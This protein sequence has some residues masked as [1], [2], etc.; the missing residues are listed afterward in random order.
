MDGLVDIM[1]IL[2]GGIIEFLASPDDIYERGKFT[3]PERYH[4]AG[5]YYYPE[6]CEETILLIRSTALSFFS[7]RRQTDFTV[8]YGDI[9]SRIASFVYTPL[10]NFKFNHAANANA[11]ENEQFR[12]M[13]LMLLQEVF[14]AV[15]E[16]NMRKLD[17]KGE[18]ILRADGK[19]LKPD[20]WQ[21]ADV[22]SIIKK[23]GFDDVPLLMAFA[24]NLTMFHLS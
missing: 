4:T 6:L 8:E 23:C 15:H 10:F 24:K 20:N 1:Y 5:R 19:I 3:Y 18:P 14:N 2:H 13:I 17:A 12:K 7:F 22:T 9:V 11:P 21:P 16:A